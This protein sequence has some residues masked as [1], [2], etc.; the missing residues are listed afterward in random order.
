M[1]GKKRDVEEFGKQQP[2]SM[3]YSHDRLKKRRNTSLD[4][5]SGLR[6]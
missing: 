2:C 3:F 4:L 5:V 1:K 6:L